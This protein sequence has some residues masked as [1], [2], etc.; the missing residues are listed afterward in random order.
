[1]FIII[2][3][4]SLFN[5]H[6]VYTLCLFFVIVK[7]LYIEYHLHRL[8]HS[9]THSLSY[10]AG[11]VLFI[12]KLSSSLNRS[13]KRLWLVIVTAIDRY[14][15]TAI[16]CC[17]AG[18]LV[19]TFC[20][21]CCKVWTRSSSWSARWTKKQLKASSMDSTFYNKQESALFHCLLIFFKNLKNFM[22]SCR[23]KYFY[24]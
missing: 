8:M 2:I 13:C 5:I 7:F 10:L 18:S 22:S 3:I 15:L 9:P 24:N 21:S 6:Y 23:N 12:T 14:C 4:P 16:S 11:K 17:S 1:M 19:S 20:N